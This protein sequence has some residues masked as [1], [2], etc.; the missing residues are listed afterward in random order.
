MKI[1]PLFRKSLVGVVVIG[2]LAVAS[3]IGRESYSANLTN[4]SVTLS[5][6]RLSFK[7]KLAAGHTLGTSQITIGTS[8]VPSI[9]TEHLY[10]GQNVRIGELYSMGSYTVTEVPNG[11]TT[12]F[13]IGAN[14]FGDTTLL[15]GDFDTGDDVIASQSGSMTV[16]F[17]TANAIASGIFQV[18]IPSAT[19]VGADGIPDPGTF[20]FGTAAPTVTCPADVGSTYDFTAGA[21]TASAVLIGS[22]WYHSY[23]CAYSGTG[24]VGTSFSTMTISNIINPAPKDAG[25]PNPHVVGTADTYKP[26]I[27]HLNNATTPI[28]T[29]TISIGAIEAVRVTATVAPQITFSIAGTTVGSYCGLTTTVDTE[30]TAVPFGELI[31]DTFASGAQ[32]LTVSTNGADG[33][34]VT[35]IENDQLSRN[36][37]ACTDDGV[38]IANCIVDTLGDQGGMGHTATAYEDWTVPTN[39]GFAYTL[40]N[41]DAAAAA[42][43]YSTTA[44]AC[45]DAGDC[46]RQFA[47][48]YDSTPQDPVEIFSSTTV[49]DLETVNVCYKISIDSVQAAGEYENYI[50]YTATANF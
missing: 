13:T 49:A 35:A 34:S 6:S 11:S 31:L 3:V 30:A 38:G 39:N 41:V 29:T 47:D 18:L 26:I 4:V 21:A 10:A 16:A 28:D 45:A 27:R 20:D 24:A 25:D 36:N 15:A 43:Q 19:T 9:S 44:G 32:A 22:Q 48:L 17:T 23:I 46:Y 8:G 1:S 33:Y 40:E 5:N 50:T 42:F 12:T 2:G 7:G 37:T 14:T